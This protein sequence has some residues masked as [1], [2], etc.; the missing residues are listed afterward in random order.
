MISREKALFIGIGS[1]VVAIRPSD[2][3]E[4][5]RTKLKMTSFVTVFTDGD[6]VYAGAAGELFC[7]DGA[8]GVIRWRNRLKGLG[9]GLISFSG[10]STV[11]VA[12]A[13]AAAQAATAG[14]VIAA[15]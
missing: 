13:M 10:A 11:E 8:S 14:A 15:S 9:S 12:A 7:L 1:H 4:I 2:G 6:T 5:W 3:Q